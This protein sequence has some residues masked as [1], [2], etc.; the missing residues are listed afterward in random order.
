MARITELRLSEDKSKYIFKFVAQYDF[1][2]TLNAIKLLWDK[3]EREFNQTTKEW[4]VPS[5]PRSDQHLCGLFTNGSSALN[6]LYSQG[7]RF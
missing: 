3:N 4:S 6:A 2:D 7:V 5:N 1:S